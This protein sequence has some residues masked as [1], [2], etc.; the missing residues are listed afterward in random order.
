MATFIFLAWQTPD[1][2]TPQIVAQKTF[3]RLGRE[4]RISRGQ[5]C[6]TKRGRIAQQKSEQAENL[7]RMSGEQVQSKRRT[8]S[9]GAENLF[10]AYGEQVQKERRTC[11]E[12]AENLFKRSGELVQNLPRCATKKIPLPNRRISLGQEKKFPWAREY[13]PFMPLL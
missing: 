1:Y 13:P 9:K 10:R 8:C 4:M 12:Q 3:R 7:F 5:S 2:A 11:S 6:A